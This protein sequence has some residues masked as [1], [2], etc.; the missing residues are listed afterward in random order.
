MYYI[1]NPETRVSEWLYSSDEEDAGDDDDDDEDDDGAAPNGR[2]TAPA[3]NGE[4]PW[5]PPPD[6]APRATPNGW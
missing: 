3:P 4:R 6:R 5:N 2:G 1:V